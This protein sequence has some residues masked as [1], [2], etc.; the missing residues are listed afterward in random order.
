MDKLV[1]RMDVEWFIR[2]VLSTLRDLNI[3]Y[4]VVEKGLVK[5][6]IVETIT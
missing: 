4:L 2:R 1:E 3:Y 6:K 5:E